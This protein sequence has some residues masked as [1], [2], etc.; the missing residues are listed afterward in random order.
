MT[1][2]KDNMLRRMITTILL[3][4]ILTANVATAETISPTT[5][6]PIPGDAMAPVMTVIS[7]A[8]GKGKVNGKT[9]EAPGI[10]KQQN[11]GGMQADIVF[12]SMLYEIGWSRLVFLFHDALV[13][14][15][16]INVGPVRSLRQVPVI[17]ADTWNAGLACRASYPYA[18]L[19]RDRCNGYLFE[20]GNPGY[21]HV[22]MQVKGRKMPENI[23]AD[24][25]GISDM[26]ID[27]PQAPAMWTFADQSDIDNAQQIMNLS[28]VTPADLKWGEKGH[29][30]SFHYDPETNQY[31]WFANGAPMKS[32]L[33]LSFAEEKAYLFD[34]VIVL[35]AEHSFMTPMLPEAAMD[36]GSSGAAFVYNNGTV[37][38]GK[39][40]MQNGLLLL[41]DEDG[42][43]LLLTPGKSYVA[44]QPAL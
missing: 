31:S 4:T 12:E 20:H 2:K 19:T 1:M 7:Y 24:V 28:F 13:R 42:I 25:N 21:D 11:W 27:A 36:E 10:G 8:N 33:D 17:L 18:Q 5:G 29:T 38:N 26:M 30:T 37:Q 43:D 9:I 23:N 6:L 14:G 35:Y 34:N 16:D 44:I 39:W 3:F 41:Q 40:C 32:W 15:E 22:M